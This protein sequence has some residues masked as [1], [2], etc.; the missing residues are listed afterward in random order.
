MSS[1]LAA[2]SFLAVY[3]CASKSGV[4]VSEVA[5]G[6]AVSA[7]SA[8][9]SMAERYPP[10]ALTMEQGKAMKASPTGY[11]G[12][13][14]FQRVELVREIAVNFQG[15]AFSKDYAED[16]SHVYAWSDLLESKRISSTTPG[17]CLSCKTSSIS[18]IFA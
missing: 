17:A 18:A 4:A 14:N 3:S 1:C 10:E 13:V 7:P 5:Q 6:D 16:R 2:A 11:G 9:A 12:S 8:E 15:S